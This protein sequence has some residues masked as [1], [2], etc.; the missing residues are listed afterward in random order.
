MRA[1]EARE[2]AEEVQKS[3]VKDILE[4]IKVQA[5][6]GEFGLS[7]TDYSTMNE[8]CRKNLAEMGYSVKFQDTQRDDGY[9]QIN[10]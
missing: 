2:I 6:R 9:W 7:I 5:L 8:Q 10:W 3:G 1:E 4:K